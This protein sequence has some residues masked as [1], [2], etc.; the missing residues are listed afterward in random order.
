MRTIMADEPINLVLV[1]L[2]EIRS[3]LKTM[4]QRFDKRFVAID[5]QF[6][7]WRGYITHTMGLVSIGHLKNEHQDGRLDAG[8][9]ERKRLSDQVAGLDSRVT[10]I[11][12]RLDR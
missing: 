9:A 10:R 2:R 5:K 4:E 11:E 3:E 1:Q 6:E 12:E 8:E 7:E